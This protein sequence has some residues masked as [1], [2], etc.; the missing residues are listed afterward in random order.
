MTKFNKVLIIGGTG[1][2][3]RPVVKRLIKD[4]YAVRLMAYRPDR[5]KLFF[6][7]GIETVYGDV[8][9]EKSLI[10]PVRGC[11]AVYINLNAKMEKSKYKTIEI[12]GTASVAR[13]SAAEGVR[14]I[15]MISGLNANE[16]DA[17]HLFIASK[18]KAEKS[19]IDSGI[20]YSIFRCCWFYESLPLLIVGKKAIM[21]GNQPLPLS[22]LAAGDYAAMVSKA[23]SIDESANRI[24]KIKGIEKM[25]LYEALSRFCKIVIPDTKISII[26]LWLVSIMAFLSPK[27]QLRGLVDFMKYFEKTPELDAD[28]ETEKILGPALTTLDDWAADYKKSII[29]RSV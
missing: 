9:D 1:M 29:S 23:F 20:P 2:L 13:V 17:G 15:A 11:D 22:W 12:E 16:A 14:R 24:F 25:P 7:D 28:N 4:G 10:E 19:L 18:L 27:R 26:P 6:G 3:G 5:A 21:F 8:T